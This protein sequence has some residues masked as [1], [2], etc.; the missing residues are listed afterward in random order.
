MLVLGVL[1]AALC[2]PDAEGV[3][4]ADAAA[5]GR[6]RAVAELR[7]EA[8]AGADEDKA[9]SRVLAPVDWAGEALPDGVER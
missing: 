8:E 3:A 9:A 1:A 2:W 7:D 4:L 5:D 6:E